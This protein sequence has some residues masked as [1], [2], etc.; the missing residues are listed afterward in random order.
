MRTICKEVA[1]F[2]AGAATPQPPGTDRMESTP[3]SPP[4]DLQ[5]KAL[6]WGLCVA[7]LNRP[8]MLARCVTHAMSQTRLPSE[9][10][11]ADASD[12]WETHRDHIAKTLAAL[13]G[14]KNV[15]LIYLGHP[16]KSSAVQRNAALREMSADVAFVIDDDSLMEPDCAKTIMTLYEADTES[17]V[18]GISGV[19]IVGDEA[20]AQAVA[21]GMALKDLSGIRMSTALQGIIRRSAVARWILKEILM[22]ARDRIFVRYDDPST[23]HGLETAQALAL[24]D[25]QYTEFIS[26]WGM[27]VR[28]RVALL[29][30]F[31]DGLL[32][33][34]P[35][36]DLDA[37]YRWGRHGVC[38]VAENA[39][40]NHIEVAAGRIKRRK[41]TALSL[42]NSAYLTRRNSKRPVRDAARFYGFAVRRVVAETLKDLIIGRFTLPQGRGAAWALARSP[43]VWRQD[44][45]ELQA[46]YADLQRKILAG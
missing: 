16:V 5:D 38:L 4:S 32:A 17:R 12:A 36:E 23:H 22:Q 31:D 2:A 46:W 42:M 26:G 43:G 18:A 9:I 10:A 7:T 28:R 34:C 11:V 41:V 40:I 27:T 14:G 39:R 13:P 29:E 6:S 37:S 21:Q 3:P 30:P 20:T 15:R 45:A 1:I 33:Y 8:D 25:T 44:D 19:N 35:T 24:P